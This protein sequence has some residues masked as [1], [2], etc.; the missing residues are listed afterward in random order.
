[1]WKALQVFWYTGFPKWGERK[2]VEKV[3]EEMQT[4]HNEFVR[5]AMGT[6]PTRCEMKDACAFDKKCENHWFCKRWEG[7]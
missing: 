7:E 3:L 1:M 2:R 5:I 4:S 6:G